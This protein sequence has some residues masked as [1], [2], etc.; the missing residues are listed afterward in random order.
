[1]ETIILGEEH[2]RI[3]ENLKIINETMRS[4][5][6][7]RRV[8]LVAVSK[9]ASV[10]QMM[11]AARL[12]IRCF[13]ENRVKEGIA[14]KEE[15]L[16][17]CPPEILKEGIEWHLIGHLQSNKARLAVSNF[18]VIHSL[19]S[20]KLA[21]KIEDAC[22]S[23]KKRQKALI[24]VNVSGEESKYGVPP[25][26][27]RALVGCIRDS[28]PSVEVLGLMTV[29]PFFSD[30][31]MTRPVFAELKRLSDENGLRELSMGMTADWRVAL[32][33]GS[34]MLRIGRGV[35]GGK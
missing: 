27:V 14:K 3:R 35:F 12:G 22:T 34:T 18:D 17:T 13:G 1:M 20:I 19:D 6:P 2:E 26:E 21:E 10:A 29:A 16:R 9:E 33:E 23:L 30:P 25:Q 24:E 28:C 31:E 4:V 15:F 32:E 7:S 11:V 8:L 5:C